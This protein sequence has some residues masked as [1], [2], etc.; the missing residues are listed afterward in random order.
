MASYYCP[1]FDV[2]RFRYQHFVWKF[3]NF[4]NLEPRTQ[5]VVQFSYLPSLNDNGCGV[6]FLNVYLTHSLW[7]L[8]WNIMWNTLKVLVGKNNI[9]NFLRKETYGRDLSPTK[10]SRSWFRSKQTIPGW[11]WRWTICS[12]G[13]FVHIRN[14]SRSWILTKSHILLSL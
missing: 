7:H 4:K 1:K 8:K 12:C 14:I 10:S 2:L 3:I 9:D 5:Y 6:F 11:E 13:I